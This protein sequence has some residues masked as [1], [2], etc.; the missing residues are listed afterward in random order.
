MYMFAYQ[1]LGEMTIV[2]ESITAGFYGLF[3]D[4]KIHT[5]YALLVDERA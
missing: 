4:T 3:S 1:A 5:Y 2:G